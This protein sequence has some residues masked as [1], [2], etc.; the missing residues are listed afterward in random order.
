EAQAADEAAAWRRIG[1]ASAPRGR[2]RP[3][4]QITA[5]AHWH[6][7]CCSL[8]QQDSPNVACCNGSTWDGDSATVLVLPEDRSAEML[9]AG[10]VVMG[11]SVRIRYFIAQGAR[12]SL[13]GQ[14]RP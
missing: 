9:T 14:H 10:R 5:L 12:R 6:V 1:P 4:R 13:A 3:R 7:P 2:P 8:R 11:G